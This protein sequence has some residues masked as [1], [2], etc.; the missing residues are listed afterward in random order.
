M[1]NKETIREYRKNQKIK[2]IQ[3]KGGRC[4]YC[5]WDKFI[6]G[7]EFKR[8]DG[9]KESFNYSKENLKHLDNYIL[10][11]AGYNMAFK[12]NEMDLEEL[13]RRQSR[14]YPAKSED[15]FS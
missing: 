6:S 2:A 5:G 10:F 1:N 13:T 11:C 14:T 4:E 3:L 7:M 9:R 15:I 8:I 12:S